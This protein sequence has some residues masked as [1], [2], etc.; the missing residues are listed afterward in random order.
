MAS[1][2]EYLH[3]ILGQLSDLEAVSYRSMMGEF[4]LYYFDTLAVT[5]MVTRREMNN[6]L[7]KTE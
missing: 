5:Q 1:S 7:Q 4:I 3:F 6:S 2:K